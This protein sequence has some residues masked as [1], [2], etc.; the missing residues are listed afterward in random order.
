ML[1][2]LIY[3]SS[4]QRQVEFQ[5]SVTY[6]ELEIYFKISHYKPRIN[7]AHT[8]CFVLFVFIGGESAYL[9]NSYVKGMT[10][11]INKILFTI[12]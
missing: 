11:G 9:A 8:V 12:V 3:M 5:R 7:H 2:L 1:V 4:L 6:W 10:A